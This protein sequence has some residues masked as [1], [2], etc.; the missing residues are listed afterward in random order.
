MEKRAHRA[1]AARCRAS[2][3]NQFAGGSRRRRSTTIRCA[4]SVR[5][6]RQMLVAA[7]AQSWNVAPSECST[8]AGVVVTCQEA[9]AR[10]VMARSPRKRPICRC[11]I[12]PSITLKDPKSFKIIGQPLLRRRQPADRDRASRSS[13]SM[14]PFPACSMRCSTNARCSAASST[15]ANVERLKALPGVHD[16]FVVARER[17]EPQRR[18]AGD[19][20]RRRHRGE[21]LVGGE[22]GAREARGYLGRGRDR[23]AKQRRRLRGARRE[24]RRRSAYVLSAPRRRCGVSA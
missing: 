24:T 4:V 16:A 1:G 18:P 13:A 17:G 8:E 7:A 19:Q 6:A 15:S 9:A 3:V 10:W 11:R 20:R 22:P 23:G 14:S 21:E 12:L 2:S 5:P